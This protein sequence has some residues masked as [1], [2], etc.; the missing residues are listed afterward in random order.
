M[1]ETVTLSMNL[2]AR[3]AEQ[4][5]REGLNTQHTILIDFLSEI[6]QELSTKAGKN[7]KIRKIDKKSIQLC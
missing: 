1:L 6:E 5:K 7:S 3:Q 2:G 4:K